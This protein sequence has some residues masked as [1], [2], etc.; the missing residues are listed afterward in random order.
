MTPP[1][2][3]TAEDLELPSGWGPDDS[4][5]RVETTVRTKDFVAAVGMIQDIA[6]IAEEIGHHPDLHLTNYN[7]LRITSWSH[8]T[9]GLTE[10]DERLVQR[11]DALIQEKDLKRE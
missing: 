1:P 9:G 10:R 4:G 3:K 6:E 8:D 7:R 5:K 11:I 2:Q